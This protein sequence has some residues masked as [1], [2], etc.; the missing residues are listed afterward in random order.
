MDKL[1]ALD[2]FVASAEEGSF[3]GAARRLEVSVPAVQKL[4]TLLEHSLGIR[5]FERSVRGVALT[6]S[7]H[8]Y[9]EACHPLLAELVAVDEALRR[10]QQ[11]PTGTLVIGAHSQLARHLLLP[12]LPRF[13]TQYPDIQIDVRVIHR[14]TDADAQLA[15]VFVLHGWPEADDLV[16]RQL[17]HTKAL[18]V[19]TPDYWASRGIPGHPRELEK[20]VCVLMRNPA[21]IVIDLWEFG[22]GAEK[23]SVKVNGWLCSNG[24][25]VVLDGVLAGEGIARLSHL[26]TRSHLEAG[27]LVPVL[28]DWEVQGGPPVNVLFRSNQRRT[29]RVRLFL[30]FVA[31]L[32]RNIEAEDQR[33]A[34]RPHWHQPG[35]GKASSV[36]RTRASQRRSASK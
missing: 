18:I 32:L 5:L 13:H 4:V 2:Y 29:P 1:R 22:R 31:A 3:A 15:D 36:L 26:T 33:S 23:A 27:R 16:H 28:L 25:E 34:A 20:H 8:T 7:G 12:A 14:L 11:R 17:G 10:S 24:R 21:G 30:D 35:Y 6:A 9:L 19:G